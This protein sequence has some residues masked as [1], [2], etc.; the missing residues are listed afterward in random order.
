MS[1]PTLVQRELKMCV[2]Y[3]LLLVLLLESRKSENNVS[4]GAYLS[5]ILADVPVQPKHRLVCFRMAI[6]K[7]MTARNYRT[8]ARFIRVIN[9]HHF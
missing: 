6:R 1:N 5:R 8:A 2:S 3:K 7:N 4:R 9:F